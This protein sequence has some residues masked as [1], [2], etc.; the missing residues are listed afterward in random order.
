MYFGLSEDQIML[1]DSVRRFLETQSSLSMCASMPKAMTRWPPVTK[2]VVGIG[3]AVGSHTGSASGLGMGVLEAALIQEMLGRF[4]TPSAFTPAY[5]M[6]VAGLN[7][8]VTADQRNVWLGRIAGGDVVMG[9]G[10]TEAVGARE[11]AGLTL[12]DAAVSKAGKLCDGRRNRD[13]FSSR[14]RRRISDN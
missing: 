11:G 2:R 6:A 5:G 9:V 12:S 10:V 8:G 4:V 14:R 7:V 3:R 13:A 1:Q